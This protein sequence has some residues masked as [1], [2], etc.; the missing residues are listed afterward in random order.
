MAS[1]AVSSQL[2][3]PPTA[4]LSNMTSGTT[5][6][7]KAREAELNAVLARKAV[8]ETPEYDAE[9]SMTA[10]LGALKFV[11]PQSRG[12]KASW[13]KL[14][15]GDIPESSGTQQQSAPHQPEFQP[16]KVST[17]TIPAHEVN[18]HFVFPQ[19][20][21]LP[22]ALRQSHHAFPPA[23]SFCQTGFGSQTH[24][25]DHHPQI[26][27]AVP[28]PAV[29]HSRGPSGRIL[30]ATYES[31]QHFRQQMM[32]FNQKA[33]DRNANNLPARPPSYQSVYDQHQLSHSPEPVVPKSKAT[34]DDPFVD[35]PKTAFRLTSEGHENQPWQTSDSHEDQ[36]RQTSHGSYKFDGHDTQPRQTSYGS[37]KSG[38]AASTGYGQSTNNKFD[39]HDNQ[40]RQTSYGSYK[41]GHAAP[42]GYGESTDNESRLRPSDQQRREVKPP[43]GLP[44]HPNPSYVPTMFRHAESATPSKPA[45]AM[46]YSQRDPKPYSSFFG[47]PMNVKQQ[48]PFG[49]G[50]LQQVTGF[51]KTEGLPP[52]S[53]KTVMYDAGARDMHRSSRDP[54]NIAS[55]TG[56]DVLQMSDPLPWKSRMAE[57][58]NMPAPF[59]G[60]SRPAYKTKYGGA[61]DG[62]GQYAGPLPPLRSSLPNPKNKYGGPR[63][64][65]DGQP[66]PPPFFPPGYFNSS[67]SA[68]KGKHGGAHGQYTAGN[69]GNGAYT[70]NNNP[71]N[72][73]LGHQIKT[74]EQRRAETEAWWTYDGRGQES[75]R[76][77]L[78]QVA[79]DHKKKKLE[80]AYNSMKKALERQ[81]TFRDDRSDDSDTTTT[82]PQAAPTAGDIANRLLAPAVANL[83]AYKEDTGPEY[84]NKFT[85]APAWAVD[86]SATGNQSFFGEDRGKTPSRV[87]RD[88]RYRPTLHEGRY[89][90]FEPNDGRVSSG[91]GW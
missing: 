88:P 37:Y 38:H 16:S 51:A 39:G 68:D 52:L 13:K 33:M 9:P 6:A 81:A 77:Y 66:W 26:Q 62:N 82:V 43:P 40:S 56:N 21:E 14:N 59:F 32:H 87:G 67:R 72:Q 1:G 50:S 22:D 79:S 76:A 63:D 48:G 47:N 90:V 34:E 7:Q 61:N 58:Y 24:P 60:P 74:P 41:S 25:Q 83:R 12:R 10:S 71:H 84:F 29:S 85:K 4:T 15:L 27:P 91:R 44:S 70:G 49:Q 36:P 55:Q 89:T 73:A 20:P 86:A 65:S 3:A 75:F 30:N 18:P 28:Y 19:L 69:R 35:M 57:V 64:G 5:F 53:T 17:N 54:S 31:P 8:K 2:P 78:E 46:N 45:S 80:D 23:S 11:K 42:T